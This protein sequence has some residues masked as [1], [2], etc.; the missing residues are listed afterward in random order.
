MSGSPVHSLS[1]SQR[2]RYPGEG[3]DVAVVSPIPFGW[4][5]RRIRREAR[6]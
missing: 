6:C 1:S 2:N 4:V 3:G 5:G